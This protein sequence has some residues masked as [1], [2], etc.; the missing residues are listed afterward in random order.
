MTLGFQCI[1]QCNCRKKL[2]TASHESENPFH[3]LVTDIIVFPVKLS[4]VDHTELE[5]KVIQVMAWCHQTPRHYLNQCWPNLIH[6]CVKYGFPVASSELINFFYFS[7]CHGTSLG[8]NEL[9]RGCVHL[10]EGIQVISYLIRTSKFPQVMRPNTQDNSDHK[11]QIDFQ[12]IAH[13]LQATYRLHFSESLLSD[14]HLSS[15]IH[16]RW[17]GGLHIKDKPKIDICKG[18]QDNS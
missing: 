6:T 2:N 12:M 4:P 5:S 8:F 18:Q 10:A 16:R 3:I 13:C 14:G 7:C 15:Y 1:R 17:S 11:L 9:T